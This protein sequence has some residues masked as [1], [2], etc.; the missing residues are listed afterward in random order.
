MFHLSRAA[1][2]Y[3]GTGTDLAIRIK[4]MTMR[5]FEQYFASWVVEQGGWVSL[6]KYCIFMMVFSV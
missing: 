4:N 3:A 6:P 5:Y 2:E 1:I